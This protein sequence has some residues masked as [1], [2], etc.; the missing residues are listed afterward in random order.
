MVKK[1][2]MDRLPNVPQESINVAFNYLFNDQDEL[3]SCFL[4][5]ASSD[6]IVSKGGLTPPSQSPFSMVAIFH[7]QLQVG[8]IGF[9]N[10]YL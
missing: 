7:K 5:N 10:T 1:D 8:D 6:L 3:K 9:L 2:I 4:C